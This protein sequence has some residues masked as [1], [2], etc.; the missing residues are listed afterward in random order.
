MGHILHRVCDC[1]LQESVK[2]ITK[3]YK[4]S[5]YKKDICNIKFNQHKEER[6]PD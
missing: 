4:F 3:M 2:Q 1:L 6:T 5:Q